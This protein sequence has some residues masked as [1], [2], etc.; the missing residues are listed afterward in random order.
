[1]QSIK[2]LI[3]A[4]LLLSAC[5]VGIVERQILT[6]ETSALPTPDLAPTFPPTA[7][8]TPSPPPTPEPTTQPSPMITPTA[9][10]PLDVA[11]CVTV[12]EQHKIEELYPRNNGFP[13]NSLSMEELN[14][15]LAFMGIESLCIPPQLGV[16]FITVDWDSQQV[17]GTK[18]RMLVIGF[19]NLGVPWSEGFIIYSTFDF[20]I[21]AMYETFATLQDRDAVRQGTMPDMITVDGVQGFTRF[22]PGFPMG[23]QSVY[24]THVFPFDTYYVAVVYDLG[25]YGLEDAAEVEAAIQRFKAGEY[26]A[27]H[28]YYMQTMDILAL[29]IEFQ[30][31]P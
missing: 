20:N 31:T 12:L 28:L 2:L 6:P 19:E 14:S 9:V 4:C 26:P 17:E 13:K 10:P 18:G 15:H 21:G 5:T 22:K 11:E 1:M 29:S 25:S 30:S 24:K 23:G 7:L 27:D 3:L 16:P 8:V